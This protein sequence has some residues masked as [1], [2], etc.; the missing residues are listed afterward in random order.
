[1]LSENTTI[2]SEAP[3]SGGVVALQG[4]ELE[5]ATN[6]PETIEAH[7][8]FNGSIIRTRFPPEPN[9]YL[10]IGYVDTSLLQFFLVK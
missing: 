2:P 1:M 7:K 6:T 9:G 10:H 8:Q 3:P 5:W 4:R